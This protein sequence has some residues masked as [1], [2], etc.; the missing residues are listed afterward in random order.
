IV[1]TKLWFFGS[2]LARARADNLRRE[3]GKDWVLR[4]VAAPA[5]APR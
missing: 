2:L 4:Q 3:A 1:G 5:G